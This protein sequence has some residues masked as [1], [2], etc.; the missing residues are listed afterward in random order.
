MKTTNNRMAGL[1][2]ASALALGLVAVAQP[3]VAGI[4][5][6][7][8]N[9]GSSNTSPSQN[10]VTAGTAEI[11]VFCHTPHGSNTSVTA[12]LWNKNGNTAAGSYLM[13]DSGNSAT[14]DGNNSAGPGNISLACL[15]CHDGTQAM[16]NIINASGAGFYDSTGGGVTGRTSASGYVWTGTSGGVSTDGKLQSYGTRIANLATDLVND[17]PI[18]MNFCAGTDGGSISTTAACADKDFTTGTTASGRWWIDTGTAG[19]FQKTDLPLYSTGASTTKVE[20]ATCH[21]PHSSTN[22]TF[23][24]ISNAGSAVCLTCHVK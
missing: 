11:C 4:S 15:T 6:T 10:H 16:D 2:S 8:H 3:A 14:F 5:S 22:P 21:D 17:H 7:R 1:L 12:P 18:G 13:Y 20:C 9:L 19:T 24:R 23:L